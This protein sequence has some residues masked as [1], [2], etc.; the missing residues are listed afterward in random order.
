MEVVVTVN[1]W[2]DEDIAERVVR[3][4]ASKIE[5]SVSERVDA[6][7]DGLVSQAAESIITERVA[8]V[9]EQI[10]TEGWTE[11]DSDLWGSGNKK[12]TLRQKLEKVLTTVD[13]YNSS[14]ANLPAIVSNEIRKNF[15]EE[16]KNGTARLKAKVDEFVNSTIEEAITGDIRTKLRKALAC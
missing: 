15:D 14:K 16:I 12:V 4:A 3:Q 11:N 6:L 5:E 8:A 2:E 10:I 7:L 9:V 13:R 1:G